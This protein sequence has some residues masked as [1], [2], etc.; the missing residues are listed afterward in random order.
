M[1]K[2]PA[3]W[4]PCSARPTL[5]PMNPTGAARCT[6]RRNWFRHNE[7]GSTFRLFYN[8][9]LLY[10]RYWRGDSGCE[11]PRLIAGVRLAAYPIW[12]DDRGYFLEVVRLGRAS[13]PTLSRRLRRSRRHSAIRA[14][15]RRFISII[16]RPICG[17][18]RRACFKSRWSICG[19]IRAP[20][21]GKIRCTPA[22]SSPGRF[23]F[24]RAWGT[25]T[26]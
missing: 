8:H 25:A 5:L 16:T 2:V 6:S 13:P 11:S 17:C 7:R 21:A 4:I 15:S 18:R 19:R 26:K 10:S 24:R 12:P 23:L 20:L 1:D 22:L 14:P 9:S 3:L